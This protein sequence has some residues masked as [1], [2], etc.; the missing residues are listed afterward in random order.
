VTEERELPSAGGDHAAPPALDEAGAVEGIENR[1]VSRLVFPVGGHGLLLGHDT[2]MEFLED[3]TP[4]YVPNRHPQFRGLINR[5][6]S[7]VP[8]FDI[9]HLFKDDQGEPDESGVLV[10]GT[11]EDAVGIFLDATPYRISLTGDEETQPPENLVRIFGEYVETS[12][13][14]GGQLF[15]QVD[16]ENFLYKLV[17]KHS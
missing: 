15:V 5:R 6:G 12:Y 16:L 14:Q 8:V 3:Q 10:L 17:Q 4:Y 2:S 9:R 11:G 7:L 13:A 1:P